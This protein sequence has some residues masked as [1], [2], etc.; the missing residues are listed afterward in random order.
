MRIS[1]STSVSPSV[2]RY[3]RSS[4]SSIYVRSYD[5]TICT[6]LQCVYMCIYVYLRVVCVC[7]CVCVCVYQQKEDMNCPRILV[8]HATRVYRH[9][10]VCVYM[11]C[12]CVCTAAWSIAAMTTLMNN[13]SRWEMYVSIR[14][15]KRDRE[16]CVRKVR[17]GGHWT[18]V[19]VIGGRVGACSLAAGTHS[20]VISRCLLRAWSAQSF[21]VHCGL[22]CDGVYAMAAHRIC[23]KA[24]KTRV[25]SELQG[26]LLIHQ[27]KGHDSSGVQDTDRGGHIEEE[28]GEDGREHGALGG[29][30]APGGPADDKRRS[31]MGVL[32]CV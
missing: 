3:V 23:I 6:V 31:T 8:T 21:P 30:D 10:C 9:A 5:L 19:E 20:K 22:R 17:A 14:E 26:I 29:N 25:P 15:E 13:K 32:S 27:T 18:R 12:V 4:V 16:E 24:P 2:S 28:G 7:V 11:Y 1:M